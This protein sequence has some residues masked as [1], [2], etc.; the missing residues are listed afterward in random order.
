MSKA[1]EQKCP[2]RFRHQFA[3]RPV[4]GPDGQLGIRVRPF[5]RAVALNEVDAISG[6]TTTCRKV[7][8]MVN[9]VITQLLEEPQ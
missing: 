7:G 5:G 8:A 4:R 1:D 3:G 2:A 9:S 6:A